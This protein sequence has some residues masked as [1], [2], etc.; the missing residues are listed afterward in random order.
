MSKKTPN[1]FLLA[2]Y[3]AQGVNSDFFKSVGALF[4]E[5]ENSPAGAPTLGDL[6]FSVLQILLIVAASVAVI[7]LVI[8]GYRYVVSRGNEEG[9]EAA[10]KTITSAIL[11]LVV[12]ILAFAIVRIIAAVLLQGQAGTGI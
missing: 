7:F 5:N 3:L 4:G 6:I 8:G 1:N 11:G 2:A 12:I 10:K 9:T